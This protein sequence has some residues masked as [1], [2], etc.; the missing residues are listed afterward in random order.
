MQYPTNESLNGIETKHTYW[1]RPTSTPG[2][3]QKNFSVIQ[4][5]RFMTLLLPSLSFRK[6]PRS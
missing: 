1:D 6:G 3:K 2:N 4:T 5:L